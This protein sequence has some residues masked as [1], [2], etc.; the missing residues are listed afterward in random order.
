VIL[1]FHH[2]GMVV[3]SREDTARELRRFGYEPES[4]IYEDPRQ[5]I[6]IQFLMSAH[7]VRIELVEPASGDSVV[8]GLLERGGV[9]PYHLAYL[10]ADIEA[11][12]NE[13]ERDG[14]RSLAA[15]TPSPAFGGRLFCFLYHK[16]V[17]LTELVESGVGEDAS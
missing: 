15:P 5:R 1:V 2:L 14:F 12:I 8:S 10:V 3:H 6:R 4:P 16:H 13:L 11:G 17:G 7:G 9:A